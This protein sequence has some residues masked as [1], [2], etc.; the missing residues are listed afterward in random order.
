[1]DFPVNTSG[2]PTAHNHEASCQQAPHQRKNVH[3]HQVAEP[4]L[5]V[6]GGLRSAVL[7]SLV[8]SA[9]MAGSVVL[10]QLVGVSIASILGLDGLGWTATV[11]PVGV[12]NA[13]RSPG[14][15]ACRCPGREIAMPLRDFSGLARIA[16]VGPGCPRLYHRAL[17]ATWAAEKGPASMSRLGVGGSLGRLMSCIDCSR[18]DRS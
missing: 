10:G 2:V 4:P 12:F 3:D 5:R 17:E 13:A 11:G 16:R 7:L 18:E 15:R 14:Y 8:A 1:V 6:L 9:N